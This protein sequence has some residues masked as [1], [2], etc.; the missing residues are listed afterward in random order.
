VRS[1][2]H[3][4]LHRPADDEGLAAFVDALRQGRSAEAV[5]AVFLSS[6]EYAARN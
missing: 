4:Y 6:A 2:Y 1:L 5:L 3:D